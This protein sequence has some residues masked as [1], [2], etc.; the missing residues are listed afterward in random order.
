MGWA[1][2]E[3]RFFWYE[4]PFRDGGISQF[5]HRKLRQLI[6][7]PLLQTE[8]VR[9]LEPHIDFVIADATDYVRGDVGYDGITGVIKLAH[10]CE[11]LG[12]DIEFHG[13]ARPNANAWRPSATPTTTKWVC[14]IPKRPPATTT[15][16]S[17]TIIMMT[18][19]AVDSHGCV[20]CRKGRAW[21]L[22]STGN[23]WIATAREWW[24]TN[25][26]VRVCWL[27]SCDNAGTFLLK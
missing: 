27:N 5:A 7:T 8:H 10:A 16:F 12:L 1:C 23:G 18:L 19:D 11:A 14:S 9:S 21:A 13:P 15:I 25:R 22:P 6:R 20:P 3:E 26:Q 4:D 24:C 2:D 17:W